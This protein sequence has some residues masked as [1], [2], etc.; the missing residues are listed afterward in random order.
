MKPAP[1]P[2][3]VPPKIAYNLATS[4]AR[5]HHYSSTSISGDPQ[6][7]QD[8]TRS[9]I[10]LRNPQRLHLVKYES[11]YS[12]AARIPSSPIPTIVP[13]TYHKRWSTRFMASLSQPTSVFTV[14]ISI[15]REFI[16]ALLCLIADQIAE[17][18]G[19]DFFFT[20]A[21]P[22]RPPPQRVP[23]TRTRKRTPSE[24]P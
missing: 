19:L 2:G 15:L 16:S 18:D 6:R 12:A 1:P 11:I 24:T 14:A 13:S 4:R 23:R 7:G 20:S 5:P 17:W 10:F 3:Q 22:I 9:P 8:E 21:L